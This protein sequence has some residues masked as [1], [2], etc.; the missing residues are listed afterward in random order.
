MCIRDSD[1]ADPD[2]PPLPDPYYADAAWYLEAIRAPEAWAAGYN[3]SGVQ[4][5]INDNGVDNTHPDLAKLDL[6]NSCGVYAPCA[7]SDGVMDSHGTVC[8]SLAAGDSNSACGVGVAP[9]AGIASCVM[10]GEC[11]TSEDFLTH[12]YDVN[13]ISSNSWGT[14]KC[15]RYATSATDCPF[16]CPSVSSADCPCDACDGDDWASGDLSATCKDAVV[17]YCTNRDTFIDDVTPCLEL[18]HYFVE[19]GYSQISTSGHNSLVDGTTNGRGGLGTVYV[20]SAGNSYE[21]GQD[22]NYE[23]HK[24]SRFTISVGALGLD[25]KHASYSSSGAPAVS[26]THLT[27]PTKA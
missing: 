27:L 17:D 23:G 5:L 22:V 14:N 1:C 15:E 18:D 24:N 20:F 10:L 7:D 19:C 4:I 3:G 16:E 21:I 13:D 6:A 2:A 25:L 9:G 11:S 8:A 26:Y 12:N